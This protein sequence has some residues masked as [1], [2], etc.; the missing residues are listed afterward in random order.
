[1]VDLT[2]M[3]S[4]GK[5]GQAKQPVTTSNNETSTSPLNPQPS[6]APVQ[7]AFPLPR[8]PG[9]NIHLHLSRL[10]KALLIFL[11]TSSSSSSLSAADI[12]VLNDAGTTG[13]AAGAGAGGEDHPPMS[14][15][16]STIDI[17]IGPAMIMPSTLAR[18]GS[19]V[20]AIPDVRELLSLLSTSCWLC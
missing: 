10:D 11:T 20:L 9:T 5:Q 16:E 13:G 1:M 14:S 15:D 18:L 19:F 3:T 17:G 7:L 4:R 8:S 6:F 12:A 2:P